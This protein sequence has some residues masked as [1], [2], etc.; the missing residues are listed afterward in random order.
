MAEQADDRSSPIPPTGVLVIDTV[1]LPSTSSFSSDLS[2]SSTTSDL[3]SETDPRPDL[4]VPTVTFVTELDELSIRHNVTKHQKRKPDAV[5]IAVNDLLSRGTEPAQPLRLSVIQR[6]NRRKLECL[7]NSDYRGAEQCENALS[8]ISRT[9]AVGRAVTVQ[10]RS[11]TSLSERRDILMTERARINAE[12]DARLKAEADHCDARY[13]ALRHSHAEQVAAFKAKWQDPEFLRQFGR[14]SQRLVTLRHMERQMALAKRYDDARRTKKMAD[15][16]QM[17]EE[18]A[19]QDAVEATMKREFVK[20][21]ER[22]RKEVE[23]VTAKSESATAE[24]ERQRTLKLAAIDVAIKQLNND[25]KTIYTKQV[26]A[27]TKDENGRFSP[28][29]QSR[30]ARFREA[31]TGELNIAPVDDSTFDR[32][33]A[34]SRK[35]KRSQLP[36]L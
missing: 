36:C 29:T 14:P 1:K 6:L 24:I 9:D 10:Q 20:M 30:M 4:K 5:D 34:M 35:K 11:R 28:R 8:S 25:R 16:Q 12:C 13:D 22:Q 32:I 21:R 19:A 15:K 26:A 31:A 7:M 3:S 17:D 2:Y 18:V 27:V 23:R 33:I